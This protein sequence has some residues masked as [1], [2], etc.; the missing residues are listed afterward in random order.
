MFTIPPE[1]PFIFLLTNLIFTCVMQHTDRFIYE[2]LPRK[3]AR[4]YAFRFVETIYTREN[5]KVK[6]KYI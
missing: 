2:G 5:Q 3:K 4:T 1:T 6:A